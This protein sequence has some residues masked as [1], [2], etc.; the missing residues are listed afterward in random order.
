V[1]ADLIWLGGLL[2]GNDLTIIGDELLSFVA[3]AY[4]LSASVRPRLALPLALLTGVALTLLGIGCRKLGAAPTASSAPLAFLTAKYGAASGA[5]ERGPRFGTFTIPFTRSAPPP[6]D[7]DTAL[8]IAML[9]QRAGLGADTDRHDYALGLLM[10]GRVD[11]AIVLL[12]RLVSRPVSSAQLW[13]DLSGAYIL[14]AASMR[15]GQHEYW[16][17]GLDAAL[18]A[19]RVQPDLAGALVN[20]SLSLDGAGLQDLAN[21]A[22]AAGQPAP[23]PTAAQRWTDLRTRLDGVSDANEVERAI[24]GRP[25]RDSPSG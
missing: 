7:A 19:A 8:A 12:E 18:R 5:K 23:S 22:A 14:R 1:T 2:P 16:F 17:R 11:E 21:P 6:R 24:A 25:T 10:T 13:A 4:Q 3:V 15:T 9:Q 20:Q